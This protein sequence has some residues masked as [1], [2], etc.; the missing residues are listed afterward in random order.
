MITT[1]KSRPANRGVP[2]WKV[3]AVAGM[4]LLRPRDPAM[5]STGIMAPRRPTSMTSPR[6][7]SYHWVLADRPPKAAVVVEPLG[8]GVDDLAEAVGAVVEP[9]VERGADDDR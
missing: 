5:A 7:V 1:P 9:G 4:C 8:E 2:V 3:P 6:V